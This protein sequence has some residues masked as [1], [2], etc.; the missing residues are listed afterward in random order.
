MNIH[1]KD[2]SWNWSS[3]TLVTWCEELTYLKRPYCWERLKATGEGDSRGCED[4]Q[5]HWFSGHESEQ[6][7]GDSEG[8]RS[9]VHCSPWDAKSRMRQRLSSNN[10]SFCAC[11]SVFNQSYLFKMNWVQNQLQYQLFFLC[12]LH[13]KSSCVQLFAVIWSIDLQAPLPMGILQARIL[14]WVA[15]PSSRGS[16]QPRDWTQVS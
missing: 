5:H 6:T 12:V 14:E 2:W 4:G 16:S 1:C 15:M 13:A 3:S 11:N 7:P 10:N 9:L 8:Q